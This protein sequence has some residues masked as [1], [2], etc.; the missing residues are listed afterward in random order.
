MAFSKLIVRLYSLL[1]SGLRFGQTKRSWRSYRRSGSQSS[2]RGILLIGGLSSN[3]AS[4]NRTLADKL[5]TGGSLLWSRNLHGHTGTFSDFSRSRLWNWIA[6]ALISL[7]KTY[8]RFG[9]RD[10]VLVGHSTGGLVVLAA[11]I[12]SHLFPKRVVD[13]PSVKLRG[14]LIFPPFGL[15]SR[16]DSRL[17]WTVAIMYYLIC[18]AAFLILAFSGPWMW[19]LSLLAYFCHLYF[20]PKISVPSGDER[21]RQPKIKRR[22]AIVSESVFLALVCIYFVFAPPLIALFARLAP[23]IW[24]FAAFGLFIVT[25]GAPL[26][27]IPRNATDAANGAEPSETIGS[28]HHVGYRW[29]PVITVANLLILQF[30]LQFLLR[31]CKRPT[32]VLEGGKDKVVIVKRNWIEAM[33]PHVELIELPEYPHSDLSQQQQVE[34]A[35]VILAW[36]ARTD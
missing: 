16:L 35:E 33:K 23:G 10:L 17:L 4:T 31:F 3:A 9:K 36:L 27:M 6:D 21:V 20:V 14:V 1:R 11:L 8:Q 22:W 28:R 15:Q 7:R 12:F 26:F 30:V 25:L 32:L 29:L 5:S 18:P 19:L 13:D 2:T 24:A 34:L